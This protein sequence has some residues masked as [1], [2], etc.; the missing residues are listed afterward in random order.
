MTVCQ[1]QGRARKRVREPQM[2]QFL[3]WLP[4]QLARLKKPKIRLMTLNLAGPG[5][6]GTP[7]VLFGR[8]VPSRGNKPLCPGVHPL[9]QTRSPHA[10][11][12]ATSFLAPFVAFFG[13]VSAKSLMPFSTSASTRWMDWRQF[14]IFC[15]S[16]SLAISL[17]VVA[18]QQWSGFGQL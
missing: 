13:D 8:T 6:T 11:R 4:C 1:Q 5:K 15:K 14:K 9:F 18:E 10:I 17:V 7:V 12:Y 16:L 3:G 2:N